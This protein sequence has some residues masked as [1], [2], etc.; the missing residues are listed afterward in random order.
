MKME[1]LKKLDHLVVVVVD[2][3]DLPIYVLDDPAEEQE[4]APE[5]VMLDE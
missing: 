4:E 1:N 2:G 3:D 5:M